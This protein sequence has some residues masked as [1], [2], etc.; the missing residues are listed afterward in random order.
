MFVRE[1]LLISGGLVAGVWGRD[2]NYLRGSNSGR[3]HDADEPEGNHLAA[4]NISITKFPSSTTSP[5]RTAFTSSFVALPVSPAN[6]G[7]L[8]RKEDDTEDKY[9]V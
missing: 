3:G 1:L 7:K 4:Y 6:A 2:I 8:T 5:V 9:P